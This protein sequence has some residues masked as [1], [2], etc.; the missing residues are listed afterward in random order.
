MLREWLR[1]RR[2]QEA[3]HEAARQRLYEEF[4]QRVEAKDA[5]ALEASRDYGD[6]DLTPWRLEAGMSLALSSWL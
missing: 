6:H 4:E 1:R 3:E 5:D 2:G